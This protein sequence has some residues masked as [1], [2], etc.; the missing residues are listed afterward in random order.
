MHCSKQEE[1]GCSIVSGTRYG[2]EATFTGG[3]AEWDFKRKLCSRGANVLGQVLLQPK[4][5]TITC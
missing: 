1:S 3:V 2:R 5:G 4:V